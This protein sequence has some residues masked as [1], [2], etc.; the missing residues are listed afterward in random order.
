MSMK[1]LPRKKF[2]GM[3]LLELTVVL[4]ILAVVTSI[5]V[6]SFTAVEDQLALRARFA[7]LIR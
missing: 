7:S 6:A 3:T 4:A 5:A 2:T 1:M